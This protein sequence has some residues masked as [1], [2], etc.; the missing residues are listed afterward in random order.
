M[1]TAGNDSRRESRPPWVENRVAAMATT[2]T[3]ELCT[4]L[5]RNPVLFDL[6]RSHLRPNHFGELD[7]PLRVV[8]EAALYLA[9]QRTSSTM[10]RRSAL[11]GACTRV[12]S[13]APT[14]LEGKEWIELFGPDRIPPEGR[15]A[16]REIRDEARLFN[17][18]EAPTASILD[19]IYEV[20][21]T[22]LDEQR[23]RSLLRSLLHEGVARELRESLY[24][25][26][27][28]PADLFS[29]MLQEFERRSSE[30]GGMFAPNTPTLADV[31]EAH[32]EWLEQFRGRGIV[33]LTT[34]MPELDRRTLG[35]R[36]L[37]FVGAGPGVGKTSLLT[38]IGLGVCSHHRRNHAVVVFV[39]LDM[40]TSTIVARIKCN[41]ADMDFTTLLLGSPGYRDGSGGSCARR[42]RRRG[43]RG[44]RCRTSHLQTWFDDEDQ[45]RLAEAARRMRDEQI[46]RRMKI[47]DRSDLG[48][49][50]TVERLAA[51]VQEFKASVGATRSLVVVD[52]LQLLAVPAH[53]ENRGDIAADRYR[54]ELLQDLLA[55]VQTTDNSDA[56]VAITE[57]RKPTNAK[58]QWG[59][60]LSELM[61]TAR[62]G[63][64]AD[65]VLLYGPMNHDELRR[66]YGLFDHGDPDRVQ[67]QLIEDGRAPI[68]LTLTKGRDGMQRGAWGLEFF[69]RR[70]QFWEVAPRRL[71]GPVMPRE[72]AP[73]PEYLRDASPANGNGEVEN[74]PPALPRR[75][76]TVKKKA[77]RRR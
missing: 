77:A 54:V 21:P 5:L 14:L 71:D 7:R 38:Q 35:L 10:P 68:T 13:N 31:W 50:V 34:G 32:D 74:S 19:R 46:G 40:P 66:Y 64:A 36:G 65:L 55:Q 2:E 67:R 28:P 72:G 11:E 18:N 4:H 44:N 76:R 16:T 49:S 3:L 6:A 61:G 1:S 52:Y 17:E 23:G 59:G 43:G 53:V 75:R 37:C 8:W 24:H 26:Y 29:E 47:L 60:G 70:T 62:L 9:D 20:D 30:V 39:T 41:L 33:G 45:H 63:Y 57:A 15:K 58:E 48:R 51:V 73:T 12:L 25:G 27:F 56:V 22:E 69:F 42:G